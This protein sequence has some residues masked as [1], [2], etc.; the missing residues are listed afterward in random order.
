LAGVAWA[1]LGV[2]WLVGVGVEVTFVT[3]LSAT[4]K[5]LPP[6]VVAGYSQALSVAFQIG[7]PTSV[8]SPSERYTFEKI[9]APFPIEYLGAGRLPV[10]SVVLA[11]AGA[12][13]G[14][15]KV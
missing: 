5:F 15:L 4:L 9:V 8:T 3:N 11:L 10:A 13:T 12:E 7:S 14:A 1:G 6:L 2:G